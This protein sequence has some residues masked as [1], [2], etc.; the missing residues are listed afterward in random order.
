VQDGRSPQD[1]PFG[2]EE[3][4][5]L[6][7]EVVGGEGQAQRLASLTDGVDGVL[8]AASLG[9]RASGQGVAVAQGLAPR[10][11]ITPVDR[12]RSHPKRSR[13]QVFGGGVPCVVGE[14]GQLRRDGV[15]RGGPVHGGAGEA[16]RGWAPHAAGV[17][18]RHGL[19]AQGAAPRP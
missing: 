11:A 5:G 4:D 13:A 9:V 14:R 10:H 12:W 18:A 8:P 16:N 1:R 17:Q 6:M 19:G 3:L 7:D 15:C 2:R